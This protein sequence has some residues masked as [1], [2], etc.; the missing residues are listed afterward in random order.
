[1]ADRA[2]EAQAYNRLMGRLGAML[3]AALV[4][5]CST[6]ITAPMDMG[7]A[8]DLSAGA[9]DMTTG[10]TLVFSGDVSMTVA[11]RPFLCHPTGENFDDLDLAGP[12]GDTTGAHAIFDVDAMF[13]LQSYAAGQL[14]TIDVGIMSATKSYRAQGGLGTASL[15][16]TGVTRPSMDPCDGGAHGMATATLD[17]V[18]IDDGGMTSPGP[19]RV[20]MTASF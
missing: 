12:L 3:L 5:G 7:A 13:A 19:G 16:I 4:A 14:R 15:T 18:V 6:G 2:L 1:M 20:M 17:E 10:C 11:C 8:A 9:N